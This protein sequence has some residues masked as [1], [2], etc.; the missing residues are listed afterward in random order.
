MSFS[1]SQFLLS[2]NS[3]S[4]ID[5]LSSPK[6]ILV[7]LFG[8]HDRGCRRGEFGGGYVL[9]ALL[10]SSNLLLLLFTFNRYYQR[11]CI[12]NGNVLPFV[13]GD[14]ANIIYLT[15]KN[16][17]NTCQIHQAC[18]RPC[19]FCYMPHLIDTIYEMITMSK[20]HMKYFLTRAWAYVNNE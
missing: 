11:V 8:L 20:W 15:R 2:V 10:P 7:L 13:L 12:V 4:T 14:T 1:V 16:E 18:R 19:A 17:R 3:T 9:S 6:F 5:R